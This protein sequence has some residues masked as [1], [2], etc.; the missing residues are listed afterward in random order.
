M[1]SI[2]IKENVTE[3]VK[4]FNEQLPNQLEKAVLDGAIEAVGAIRSE[5]YA[6][7]KG[8][9]GDLARSFKERFLGWEKAIVGAAA[10]SELVY[11]GVQDQGGT[12]YPRVRKNLAVP[13]F[14]GKTLPVGKW[15]R[16]FDKNELQLIV[17]KNGS[18]LLARVKKRKGQDSQIEPMFVLKRSVRVRA[19]YY[20]EA[21]RQKAL[22]AIQELLSKS[23]SIAVESSKQP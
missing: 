18:P 16:H 1:I 5:L 22:P 7:A 10:E 12:I 9:T 2:E 19:K 11:A 21:A 15:P 6:S 17:R 3:F 4:A 20:L 13:I 14:G 8:R 23:V